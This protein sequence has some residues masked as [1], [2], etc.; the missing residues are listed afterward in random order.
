MKKALYIFIIITF[1]ALLVML[2][3]MFVTPLPDWVVR[4][5]GITTLVS[6]VVTTF[7]FVRIRMKGM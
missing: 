7:V 3:N 2:A 6:L 1:L 4:V 5:A